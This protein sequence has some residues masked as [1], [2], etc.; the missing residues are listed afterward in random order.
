MTYRICWRV[1]ATGATGHGEPMPLVFAR[2][3]LD[4]IK[5]LHPEMDHWLE[6]VEQ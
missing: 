2:A 4:R 5:A 3:W 1:V 6:A